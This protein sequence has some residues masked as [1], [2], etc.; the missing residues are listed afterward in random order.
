MWRRMRR[1]MRSFFWRGMGNLSAR[2]RGKM[3]GRKGKEKGSQGLDF[4]VAKWA[5]RC[6]SFEGG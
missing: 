6:L 1:R 4:G 5:I 2:A 3:M